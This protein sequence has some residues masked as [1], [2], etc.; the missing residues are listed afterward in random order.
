MAHPVPHRVLDGADADRQALD[1]FGF[2]MYQRDSGLR[3]LENQLPVNLK[4]HVAVTDLNGTDRQ[5]RVVLP[6][7]R[8]GTTLPQRLVECTAI[9]NVST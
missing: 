2:Q 5:T 6:K 9:D 1:G 4:A 3:V 7:E 8:E